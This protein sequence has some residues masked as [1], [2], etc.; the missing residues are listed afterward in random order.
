MINYV[1]YRPF[2]VQPEIGTLA[3]QDSMQVTI[4]FCPQKSGDYKTD[5]VLHYDTGM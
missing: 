2:S 3:V 5:L 4:E 1:F